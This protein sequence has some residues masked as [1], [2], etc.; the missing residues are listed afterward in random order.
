VVELAQYGVNALTLGSLYALF[1]LGIA[2]IFGIMRLV[3]FAHGELVLAGAYV[4][5]LLG[6]MAAPL[7]AL[8]VATAILLALI[9]E[10]TAFRPLRSAD[11]STLLV[12]SFGVSLL[13]QN[14]VILIFG[15]TPRSGPVPGFLDGLFTVGPVSIPYLNVVTVAATAVLLAGLAGFLRWTS[16]G[17]QMRAA[18]EDFRTARLLGVRADLVIALAFG[19]SGLLAGVSAVLLFAE[20]GTA[21]Y[22][23]G[24]TP[25]LVGLIATVVGGLRSLVGAVVAGLL[26]GATSVALQALLPLEVR[27]FRDAFLFGLVLLVLLVRPQGLFARASDRERV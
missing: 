13:L 5:T 18:A 9:M 8:P 23:L 15:P 21:D 11:S 24:V 12:A 3:N 1:A 6:G 17:V 20:T 2:L 25:L 14:L 19:I 27:N 7:V 16:L 4:M 10:R 26:L 22:R